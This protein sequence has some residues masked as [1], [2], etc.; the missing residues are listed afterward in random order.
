VTNAAARDRRIVDQETSV[1]LGTVKFRLAD[2]RHGGAMR[3]VYHDLSE[4]MA[5]SS[6]ELQPGTIGA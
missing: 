2:R 4:R 6:P 3:L 5:L 1:I